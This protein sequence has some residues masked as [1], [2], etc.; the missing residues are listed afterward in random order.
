[1]PNKSLY[2]YYGKEKTQVS[3]EFEDIKLGKGFY[4]KATG[5]QIIHE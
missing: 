4:F 3:E 1:M 5:I 2:M